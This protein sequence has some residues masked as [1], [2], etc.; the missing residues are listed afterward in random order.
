MMGMLMRF[1][2]GD[3]TRCRKDPGIESVFDSTETAFTKGYTRRCAYF[4][5]HI[6]PQETGIL[7]HSPVVCASLQDGRRIQDILSALHHQNVTV[8]ALKVSRHYRRL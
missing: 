2:H 4:W 5:S 8:D 3:K 1:P 6:P 7:I